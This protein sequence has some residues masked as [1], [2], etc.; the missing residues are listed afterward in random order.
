MT[1]RR[2]PSAIRSVTGGTR[3]LPSGNTSEYRTNRH[4]ESGQVA[5]AENVA[6]HDLACREN[7][8]VR[9]EALHLSPLI[10]FHSEISERD[11]R[12]QRI[13]MERRAVNGL[14]P[15]RLWWMDTFRAAVIQ[16]L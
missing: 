9:S 6:G 3:S 8:W 1:I 16:T 10:H 13:A 12:P 7:V 4:P 11:S 2:S 15:V 14:R 5:L